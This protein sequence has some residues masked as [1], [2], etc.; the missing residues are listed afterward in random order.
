MSTPNDKH[1][2]PGI[3]QRLAFTTLGSPGWNFE[4]TVRL[5]AKMGFSAIEIRGIGDELRTEKLRC[6]LPEN[7][8]ETRALLNTHAVAICGIGTSIMLHDTAAREA[9]LEEARAALS[10]ADDL[11]VPYIRVFGNEFPKEQSRE[12][13]LESVTDSL[14]R[15]C[16]MAAEMGSAR[17]LLEIHGDFNTIESLSGIIAR[18][19]DHPAFGILWDIAHSYRAYGNDFMPFY[20]VIRDHVRHVHIKDCTLS[21]DAVALCL[22]GEGGIDIPQMVRQLEA[23]GYTGLYSFEWEKRWHM[24]LEEPEIAYP[25][26]V[27]YMK[28]ITPPGTVTAS[29]PS[30]S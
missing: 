24:E 14:L 25:A 7:R 2:S 11:G 17:V 19:G 10:I 18:A 21:G 28:A 29:S 15:L 6:F 8:D 5:A 22:C 27:Q 26:Y 12:I 13:T 30:L 4:K 1:P 20:R 9:H 23:D 16:D 3:L